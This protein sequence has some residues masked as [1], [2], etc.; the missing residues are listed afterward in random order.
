MTKTNRI[1][2]EAYPVTTRTRCDVCD[3]RIRGSSGHCRTHKFAIRRAG[4]RLRKDGLIMDWVGNA[5]WIWDA[6]GEVL[7]IG[8]PSKAKALALLDLGVLDFEV[9]EI[10]EYSDD[11]LTV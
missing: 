5:W 8:Q 1:P 3:V 6:R 2:S 7:V 4:V 11:R 10:E 9:E